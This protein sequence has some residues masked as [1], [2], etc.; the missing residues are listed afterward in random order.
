MLRKIALVVAVLLAV[1]WFAHAAETA[2][3]AHPGVFTPKDVAWGPGPPFLPA[4]VKIAVLQ[5]DPG[6]PGPFVIRLSIPAG[7]K[8]PAHNHPTVE[9]VTVI[10][11]ELHVG[12]GD[13][14]DATKGKILPAGSF[15]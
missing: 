15:A 9:N 8:I 13:K 1:A 3:P 6:K 4:G 14:L 7:Y 12:M 2:S 11:G 10:S 5:G